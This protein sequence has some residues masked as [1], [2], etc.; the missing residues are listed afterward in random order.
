M[1]YL[2]LFHILP[3]DIVK[4]IMHYIKIHYKNKIINFYRTRLFKEHLMSCFISSLLFVDNHFITSDK[5]TIL[6]FI[7]NNNWSTKYNRYFFG[8][9]LQ[10]Y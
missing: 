6:H 10:I 4:I 8:V 1:K 3:G 9:V 5:I 7:I 2:L